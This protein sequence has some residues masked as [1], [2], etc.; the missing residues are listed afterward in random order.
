MIVCYSTIIENRKI[1]H[2][3]RVFTSLSIIFCQFACV[4]CVCMSEDKG[5]FFIVTSYVQVVSDGQMNK[6]EMYV[7]PIK[8]NK[9]YYYDIMWV[10]VYDIYPIRL[11]F[12]DHREKFATVEGVTLPMMGRV[13]HYSEWNE[14]L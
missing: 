8:K 2:A 4:L 7:F 9:Y 11:L 12:S 6:N 1:H 5:P 3:S 13:I 14:V 10:F